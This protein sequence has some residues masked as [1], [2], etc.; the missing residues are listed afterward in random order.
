MPSQRLTARR[1][2]VETVA[3][4]EWTITLDR[5]HNLVKL[6]PKPPHDHDRHHHVFQGD[7]HD[8][9]DGVQKF[10]FPAPTCSFVLTDGSIL[11]CDAPTPGAAVQDCHVFTTDGKHYA[12]GEADAFDENVGLAFVQQED[13]SFFSTSPRPLTNHCYWDGKQW[14]GTNQPVNYQFQDS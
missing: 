11:V 1:S 5:Q 12:L 8:F 9:E 2:P 3:T 6:D 7:P 4:D 10:D 14:A 13:G